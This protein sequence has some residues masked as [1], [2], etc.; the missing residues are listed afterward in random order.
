M[1]D[2]VGVADDSLA[3]QEAER[4]RDIRTRGPH[5]D[6]DAAALAPAHG[7][8]LDTDLER[9]LGGE[10][11]L[12]RRARLITNALYR[13]IDEAYVGRDRSTRGKNVKHRGDAAC[14]R[15]ASS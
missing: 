3:E 9:L 7:P 13:D 12:A 6:R 5:G 11:V 15:H 4:E 1:S 14:N 8:T 2:V 10:D